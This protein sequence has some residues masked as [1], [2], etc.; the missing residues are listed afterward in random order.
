MVDIDNKFI[1]RWDSQNSDDKYEINVFCQGFHVKRD[2]VAE[3]RYQFPA[4]RSKKYYFKINPINHKFV[5]GP[6]YQTGLAELCKSTFAILAISY[7]DTK[8]INLKIE[9]KKSLS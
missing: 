7:A 4:D 6:V 8:G 5:K 9:H 1:L 3:P 2:V